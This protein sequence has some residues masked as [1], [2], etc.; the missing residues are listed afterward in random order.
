MFKKDLEKRI[1]ALESYLGIKYCD[2]NG[3]CGDCCGEYL[4]DDFAII[5]KL[6][7]NI[8]EVREKIK[9][10]KKKIWDL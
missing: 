7:K 5:K 4:E 10:P 2:N 1:M 3:I 6:N 9:L 8:D